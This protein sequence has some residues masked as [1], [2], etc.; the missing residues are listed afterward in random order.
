[1]SDRPAPRRRWL[2]FVVLA[3]FAVNCLLIGLLLGALFAAPPAPVEPVAAPPAWGG[4]GQHA[5][6]LPQPER[7]KFLMAMRPYRPGIR[8]ARAAL[9]DARRRLAATI[10]QPDYNAGAA[11][12][13]FTDVRV[14]AA[15]L[16][17][18]VQEATA[19]ALA[20]LSPEFRR[21][22]AHALEGQP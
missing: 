19:M 1:M 12:A 4:F 21:G 8:A 14:R 13:A 17:E 6:Q 22:L 2:P 7:R 11:E 5:A 10:A 9:A 16:Q 15:A 20:T 3:S 18:H